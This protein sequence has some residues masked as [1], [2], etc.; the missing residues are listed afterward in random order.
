MTQ[1][2]TTLKS[3]VK[4]GRIK[5]A[6]TVLSD[7]LEGKHDL[8]NQCVMHQSSLK[9]TEGDF[10]L[11]LTNSNDV[12]QSLAKIKYGVL[13]LIDEVEPI[14]D[15]DAHAQ[16]R[17][18]QVIETF[19]EDESQP[20]SSNSGLKPML[21]GGLVL[22]FGLTGWGVFSFQKP[23]LITKETVTVKIDTALT[24]AALQ[25]EAE[26]Y[27]G[28]KKMEKALYA[29][30][31]GLDLRP[32]NSNLLNIRATIYVEQ[33]LPDKAYPDAQKAIFLNPN[34]G[35]FYLTM[36]QIESLR[37]NDEKFYEYAEIAL[38]KRFEIWKY[39]NEPGLLEHKTE[40][41]FKDLIKDYQ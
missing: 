13:S 15:D 35:S 24:V 28:Q 30:Q 14:V 20:Q 38:K 29:V 4:Q 40:K 22:L 9:K 3:L 5:L 31:K 18:V 10:A 6:L 21:I 25:K 27:Y 11:G 41:R 7:Y 19:K 33:R 36:A 2:I 23:S 37:H 1:F 8:Y 16:S 34:D 26:E 12:Q 32:D 17:A 39:V